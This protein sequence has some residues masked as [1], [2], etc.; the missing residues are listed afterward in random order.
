MRGV[1]AETYRPQEQNKF[2]GLGPRSTDRI[3]LDSTDLAL[4]FFFQLAAAGANELRMVSAS[5]YVSGRWGCAC[6]GFLL[7]SS[8]GLLAAL[9]LSV[10][11]ESWLGS[12]VMRPSG[13]EGLQQYDLR[14][15]SR[16]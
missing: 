11:W 3:R 5:M 7:D 2:E 6:G 13:I 15:Q 10:G 9:V 1:S 12:D 4:D 8:T 16:N 14:P